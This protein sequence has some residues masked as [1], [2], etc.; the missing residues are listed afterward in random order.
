MEINNI[1]LVCI[2]NNKSRQMKTLKYKL[3]KSKTQ[4]NDYCKVLDKLIEGK[5]KDKEIKDEI[6]LLAALIEIWD[7]EH[8]SFD[9]VD[10]IEL[11]RNLMA[12]R[13]IRPVQLADI[14]GVNKSLVSEI[15]NYKKGISKKII[16]T[17]ANY[18]NVSQEAFNRTY[19]LK[20]PFN[21]KLRNSNASVMNTEKVLS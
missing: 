21:S 16:R 4:Y 8:N 12:E 5:S 20:S 14:L 3:I 2:K 1:Q 10:P 9:D 19:S 13:D 6:E 15:M 18:F 17:L 11:L 7:S